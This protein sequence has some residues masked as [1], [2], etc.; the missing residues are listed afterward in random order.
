MKK[1]V[2]SCPGEPDTNTLQKSRMAICKKCP[3]YKHKY[4][5]FH[6]CN[7]HLYLNPE[8]NDVSTSKRD[9]YIQGCGCDLSYRTAN[10]NQHCI[11]NKW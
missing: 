11:C 1:D 6:T 2:I 4:F 10:P 8:T 7:E 9:G 3:L 5:V